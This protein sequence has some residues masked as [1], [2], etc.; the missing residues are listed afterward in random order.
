M[1]EHFSKLRMKVLIRVDH[2]SNNKM[3][4]QRLLQ[5]FT[6]IESTRHLLFVGM[7]SF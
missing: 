5:E 4:K 1:F 3:K 2:P 7:Y 6:I